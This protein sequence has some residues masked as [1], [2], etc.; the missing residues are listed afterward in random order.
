MGGEA[1]V[2][3]DPAVIAAF[4]SGV[5]AVLGSFLS[6]WLTKRHADREC[7]RRMQAL[8]DGYRMARE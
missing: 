5:V 2:S 4:F 6:I 1:W 8:H 3:L 7:E